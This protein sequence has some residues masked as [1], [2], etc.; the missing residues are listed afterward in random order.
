MLHDSFVDTLEYLSA[1]VGDFFW[2]GRGDEY[3]FF[4]LIYSASKVK[5]VGGWYSAK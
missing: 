1:K 4:F 5:Y 3:N 2:I